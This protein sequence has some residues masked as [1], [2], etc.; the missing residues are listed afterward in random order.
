MLQSLSLPWGTLFCFFEFLSL[1]VRGGFFNFSGTRSTHSACVGIIYTPS[2]V[3]MPDATREARRP[4]GSRSP[5]LTL[6]F[7]GLRQWS[8]KKYIAD[9]CQN[10]TS[11]RKTTVFYID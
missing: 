6:T 1:A 4:M 2:P 8:R 5:G 9:N 11:I 7:N 10:I 3:S